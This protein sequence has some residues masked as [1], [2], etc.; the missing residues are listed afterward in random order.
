MRY[1]KKLRFKK[2]GKQGW[3]V[4]KST[5]CVAFQTKLHLILASKRLNVKSNRLKPT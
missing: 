3:T 5:V 4:I 1:I 2:I